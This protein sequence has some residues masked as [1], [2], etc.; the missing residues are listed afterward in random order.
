MRAEFYDEL[1]KRKRKSGYK[2]HQIYDYLISL[3]ET[4]ERYIKLVAE[5]SDDYGN[6]YYFATTIYNIIANNNELKSAFK[7]SVINGEPWLER[8]DI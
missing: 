8:T 3:K 1:P 5:K 6:T 7:L 2:K 4:G